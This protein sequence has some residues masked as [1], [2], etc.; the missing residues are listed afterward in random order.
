[1]KR[2]LRQLMDFSNTV[3]LLSDNLPLFYPAGGQFEWGDFGMWIKLI[4]GEP[5]DGGLVVV[6]GHKYFTLQNRFARFE[7]GMNLSLSRYDADLLTVLQIHFFNVIGMHQCIRLV[8]K[9][10]QCFAPAG[11]GAG[12][13]LVENPTGIQ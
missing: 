13:V 11:H 6:E 10:D 7:R 5:V 9:I 3:V 12:M 8:G 2:S 1:M 4:A